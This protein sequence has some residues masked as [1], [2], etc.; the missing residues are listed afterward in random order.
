MCKFCGDENEGNLESIGLERKSAGQ[1]IF[2]LDVYLQRTDGELEILAVTTVGEAEVH[3][4]RIKTPY[5][6][7]CG[8]KMDVRKMCGKAKGRAE[9]G[10]P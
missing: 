5:C 6:P 8:R 1:L 10:M 4:L 9:E 3:R 2:D 7:M